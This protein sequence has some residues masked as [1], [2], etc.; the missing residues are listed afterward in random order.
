MGHAA[1]LH[2]IQSAADREIPLPKP[3]SPKRGEGSLHG[4]WIG[5]RRTHHQKFPAAI[6]IIDV[7]S[8]IR[9]T[10]HGKHATKTAAMAMILG[11][12]ETV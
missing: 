1:S 5:R 4:R 7:N 8:V 10:N 12:N 11:T 9:V 2:P 3:L 6:K